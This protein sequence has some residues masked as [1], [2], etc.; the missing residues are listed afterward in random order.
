[1]SANPVRTTL[2][3]VFVRALSSTAERSGTPGASGGVE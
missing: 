2:E 1:V 3:D